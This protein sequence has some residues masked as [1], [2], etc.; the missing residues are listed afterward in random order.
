MKIRI[1]KG[2]YKLR[3]G[4]RIRR[5][6]RCVGAGGWFSAMNISETKVAASWCKAGWNDELTYIRRKSK[7]HTKSK[8]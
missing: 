7:H 2:W 4:T 1:P 6:D 5:G 3:N 8:S